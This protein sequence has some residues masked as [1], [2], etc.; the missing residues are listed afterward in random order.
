MQFEDDTTSLEEVRAKAEESVW[1]RLAWAFQDQKDE[2]IAKIKEELQANSIYPERHD[3]STWNITLDESLPDGQIIVSKPV[4]D[5]LERHMHNDTHDMF[6]A[7]L[8]LRARTI[9]RQRFGG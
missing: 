6:N 1:G 5:T 2:R 4:W 7:M 8:E 9:Y 3:N